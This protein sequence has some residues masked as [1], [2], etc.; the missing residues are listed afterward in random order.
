SSSILACFCTWL[1]TSL[2]NHMSA[3]VKSELSSALQNHTWSPQQVQT[4]LEEAVSVQCIRTLSRA[5]KI[6]FPENPL[7]IFTEFLVECAVKKNFK[8]SVM[9]VE[10]FKAACISLE[11]VVPCEDLESAFLSDRHWIATVAVHTTC[12]TL[13]TC[14]SSSYHE[15]LFLNALC[16]ASFADDLPVTMPDFQVLAKVADCL[17]DSGVSADWVAL[18]S[19]NTSAEYQEELYRCLCQLVEVGNYQQALNFST[20]VG[21]PEDSILIS[22]WSNE[23]KKWNDAA[24]SHQEDD[25]VH[26]LNKCDEAFLLAKLNCR[27]ATNF[28]KQ[29]A[30]E[31]SLHRERYHILKCCLKWLRELKEFAKD[32]SAV[33]NEENS[34]ELEMWKCLLQSEIELEETLIEGVT[35]TDGKLLCKTKAEVQSVSGIENRTKLDDSQQIM[36]L[37]VLIGKLLDQGDIC[38]ACRLEAMFNHHNQDLQLLLVCMDL[39]EGEITPY[40]LTPEH[41]S[42]LTEKK[43][44]PTLGYKRRS[45]HSVRLNSTSS[46]EMVSP[47]SS[48]NKPFQDILKLEDPLRLLNAA[49]AEE[50]GNKWQMAS[51]I[52]MAAQLNNEDL[53]TLLCDEI[54]SA[55][56]NYRKGETSESLGI[57]LWG[58]KM[59][60][61][62]HRVLELCE[63]PSK[64]GTKLLK[65]AIK[66][67]TLD[68]D[69]N[70]EVVEILIRAHDCYTAALNMEGI[71]AILQ[72]VRTLTSNLLQ[73][74]EWPLMVRL[75][76]GIGRYTE[77]NYIFQILKDNEQFEYLLRKGQGDVGNLKSAILDFLK[78]HCPEDRESFKLV[79]LHYSMFSELAKLWE[80]EGHEVVLELL[81]SSSPQK[82]SPVLLS[83]TQET[84]QS[85]HNAMQYFTHAAE[86]YLKAEKLTK[87]LSISYQ[88]ELVALQTS[89]LNVLSV[90]HQADCLLQLSSQEVSNIITCKL[91]FPQACIVARA[92]GHSVDWGEALYQHC[93]A[94]GDLSYLPDFV[95]NKPLTTSLVEDVARS[96]FFFI[97]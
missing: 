13:A 95:Y 28:F 68:P 15:L 32:E 9:K 19:T 41:R 10:I 38:T 56:T 47:A 16:E 6:F 36:R 71:A 65:E 35:V 5:F 90:G 14:F 12:I 73:R 97:F 62:F 25:F 78:A 11:T 17:S 49:M 59:E 53:T 94:E 48:H 44:R 91:S 77:M 45:L 3:Q 72:R 2:A 92:Y 50:S 66:L 21:L 61:N 37:D 29:L 27:T 60:N 39:A 20:L 18:C 69:S 87:A 81:T 43:T 34:I 52:L 89:L 84:R 54:V 46:N 57:M 33:V 51:D 82:T 23:F 80:N 67:G 1:V 70:T 86:Y 96:F 24:E 4:L 83:N 42:L 63:E 64:L 30:D 22:Q 88:A 93:I 74:E 8:E 85:L 75:L 79:S 55:I 7:C 40:Q 76:T 58:C 31:I 26:K